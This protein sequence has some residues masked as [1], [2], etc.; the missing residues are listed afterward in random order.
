MKILH[1]V[2]GEFNSTAHSCDSFSI[3]TDHRFTALHNMIIKFVLIW[4]ARLAHVLMLMVQLISLPVILDALSFH[5]HGAAVSTPQYP[6][7]RIKSTH[8]PCS[9]ARHAFNEQ[10]YLLTLPSPLFEP[11]YKD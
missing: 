11:P 7:Y 4:V 9:L 1:T 6:A 5:T 8:P 3:T 2:V 10:L